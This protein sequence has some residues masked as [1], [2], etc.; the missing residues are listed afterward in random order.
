M[1]ENSGELGVDN[2]YLS[3]IYEDGIDEEYKES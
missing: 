2:F 3:K 1:K